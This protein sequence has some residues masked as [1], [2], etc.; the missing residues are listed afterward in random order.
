MRTWAPWTV[1]PAAELGQESVGQTAQ[2]VLRTAGMSAVL[3]PSDAALAGPLALG[4]ECTP[5][6]Q[7]HAPHTLLAR[8]RDH[9]L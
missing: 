2:Q 3:P 1:Q 8:K 9:F 4:S 5:P 6:S 7:T